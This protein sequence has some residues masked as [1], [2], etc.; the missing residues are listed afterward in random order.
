M[1]FTG[2]RV[3]RVPDAEAIGAVN[4]AS[5]RDRLRGILPDDA[6]AML[7]PDDLSLVWAGSILNPPSTIARVLVA[8]EGDSLRGY[9][10][11]AAS[12]DPD[13]D[14][15]TAEMVALEVDPG[16]QRQGHG[17]RLMAAIVDTALQ[18]GITA[19]TA[20]C[21]LDDEVRRAYLQ[22]AGWGPDSARRDLAVGVD[23]MGEPVLLRE[24]RLVT[25]LLDDPA[26]SVLL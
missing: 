11:I 10:A 21:P 25:S 9:A 8:V 14:S 15:T 26:P 5:W 3:A 2:V 7:Q 16:H 23:E 18:S 20:W 19:L 6:L 17:S 4:T 22:S 24:A 1:T 13:A 12:G